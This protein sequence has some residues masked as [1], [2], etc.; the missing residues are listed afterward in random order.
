MSVPIMF[1]MAKNGRPHTEEDPAN[2]IS[3]YG[4]SNVKVKGRSWRRIQRR[5]SCASPGS[6]VRIAQVLSMPSSKEPANTSGSRPSQISFLSYFYTEEIAALLQPFLEGEMP[7]GILHLANRGA[8][9][10]GRNTRS[11]RSIAAIVSG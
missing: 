6:L 4:E 7:S 10:A 1:L 2:P 3:I 8:P 9:V 11:G 5:W